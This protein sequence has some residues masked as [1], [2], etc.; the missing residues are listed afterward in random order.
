MKTS[1]AVSS[2]M[3]ALLDARQNMV[4]PTKGADNPFFKSKYADYPAIIDAVMAHLFAHDLVLTIAPGLL[5]DGVLDVHARITH[6]TTGQYISTTMGMPLGREAT[7]QSAGSAITY[8]SRYLVQA[9]LC[10]PSH[11]DDGQLA[12]KE[13]KKVKAHPDYAEWKRTLEK[14]KDEGELEKWIEPR[15]QAIKASLHNDELNAIYQ[16]MLDKFRNT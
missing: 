16:A 11:D 3:P 8:A 10:L 13:A 1:N 14:C 5:A 6:A 15:F 9:L 2:L 12:T 7:P 4:P